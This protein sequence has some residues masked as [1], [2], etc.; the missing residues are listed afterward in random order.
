VTKGSPI[1]SLGAAVAIRFA[2]DW[3]NLKQTFCDATTFFDPSVYSVIDSCQHHLVGSQAFAGLAGVPP[4]R[5][6]PSKGP[7][8]TEPAPNG[9]RV[10]VRFVFLWRRKTELL[11]M[12]TPPTTTKRAKRPAAKSSTTT[13]RILGAPRSSFDFCAQG[14]SAE[15]HN[16]AGIFQMGERLAELDRIILESDAASIKLRRLGRDS[17]AKEASARE[18][19]AGEEFSDLEWKII[20][21]RSFT[22][23]GYYE[24]IRI[25]EKAGFAFDPDDIADIFWRLAHEAGRLGLSD[26]IPRRC[27]G[28]FITAAEEVIRISKRCA[29][30]V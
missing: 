9:A 14:V 19:E 29:A 4:R 26:T 10:Q 15:T 3:C 17:E 5:P 13:P 20:Y 24:K 8:A 25:L 21:T 28:H 12:T 11:R 27:R 6:A 22:P 16:D 1:R 18:V 30:A 2:P 7:H 23:E